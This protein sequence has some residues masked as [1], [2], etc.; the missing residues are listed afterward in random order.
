MENLARPDSWTGTDTEEEAYFGG[1]LTNRPYNVDM[2]GEY[3]CQV[4]DVTNQEHLGISNVFTIND[5]HSYSV[6]RCTRV[7]EVTETLCADS[8]P[9]I[10]SSI[11]E[12]SPS[13][14]V[15]LINPSKSQT[16]MNELTTHFSMSPSDAIITSSV[17]I[18]ASIKSSDSITS[19]LVNDNRF[20]STEIGET[21][22][23]SSSIS[24]STTPGSVSVK[25]N[26]NGM[27][28][29]VSAAAIVMLLLIIILLI[30]IIVLINTKP[31]QRRKL[32]AG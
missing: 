22:F 9:L 32:S 7:Q 4:I 12:M 26:D 28:L 27:L 24:V 5:P 15:G 1:H 29:V 8:P 6:G 18:V 17:M 31:R 19:S 23:M 20:T 16:L 3:W 11:S 30:T 14:S 10:S 21:L 2:L 13:S 25:P